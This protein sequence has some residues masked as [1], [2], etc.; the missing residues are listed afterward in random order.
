MIETL[1]RPES[2]NLPAREALFTSADINETIDR[3][4]DAGRVTVDPWNENEANGNYPD[5]YVGIKTTA[6]EI[7]LH[8]GVACYPDGSGYFDSH[9][10]D[11]KTSEQAEHEGLQVQEKLRQSLGADLAPWYLRDDQLSEKID[12]DG[13]I[14]QAF[15]FVAG[16]KKLDMLN[17]SDEHMVS[18]EQLKQIREALSSVLNSAG[19]GVMNSIAGVA[20]LNDSELSGEARDT[21]TTS[22]IGMFKNYNS[23]LLLSDR[24]LWDET[25]DSSKYGLDKSTSRLQT[26]FAHELGHAAQNMYWTTFQK[27]TQWSQKEYEVVDDYGNFISGKQNR[28]GSPDTTQKVIIDGKLVEVKTKDHFK[29]EDL[30]RVKPNTPYGGSEM[31]EDFAESAV[32]FF[33]EGRQ[34]DKIDKVRA[35]AISATLHEKY[36]GNRI[37]NGPYLVEAREVDLRDSKG[38]LPEIPERHMTV[39]VVA[40]VAA[41][42]KPPERIYEYVTDDYGNEVYAGRNKT[43]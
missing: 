4:L 6:S 1:Q 40:E 29:Q 42:E 14:S 18:P 27:A 38:T 23:V 28:L 9:Q 37:E 33:L 11:W 35:N 36:A 39:K 25:L 34:T 5:V 43:R 7:D 16:G 8:K 30:E 15:E 2:Q 19:A 21:E 13:T 20:I 41:T 32:P 31:V 17:F 12:N 3:A 22:A 24:L 10:F 26:T